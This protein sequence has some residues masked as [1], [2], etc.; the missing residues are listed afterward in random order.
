MFWTAHTEGYC[1]EIEGIDIKTTLTFCIYNTPRTI[2]VEA[3]P[4][5]PIYLVEEE[6]QDPSR[7][8]CADPTHSSSGGRGRY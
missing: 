4:P 8:A 6:I 2:L 3:L 7:Q 1:D 5:P